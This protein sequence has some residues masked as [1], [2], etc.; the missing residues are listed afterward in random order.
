[1]KIFRSSF[2]KIVRFIA[3]VTLFLFSW[4][5]LTQ[6]LPSSVYSIKIPE[7]YGRVKQRWRAEE[8][9]TTKHKSAE[10]TK[11]IIH[12]QDAHTSSEAQ[13]NI[14]RIIEHLVREESLNIIGV[15]GAVGEIDLSRFRSFP[16]KDARDIVAEEF[17]EKGIFGG[18]EYSAIHSQ[19]EFTL[20]GA[21]D[22]A[23]FRDNFK[24]Y[25]ETLNAKEDILSDIAQLET[26]LALLREK[27]F[28]LELKSFYNSL[29]AYMDGNI[30]FVQ[31]APF[32]F[33]ALEKSYE[34]SSLSRENFLIDYPELSRFK[35]ILYMESVLDIEKARSERT[36]IVAEL[37][38]ELNPSDLA[39]AKLETYHALFLQTKITEKEFQQL[40]TALCQQYGVSRT[41]FRAFH[42]YQTYLEKYAQLD[43]TRLMNEVVRLAQVTFF[44]LAKNRDEKLLAETSYHVTLLKKLCELRAVNE[45]VDY[46]RSHTNFFHAETLVQ[47]IGELSARYNIQF[48]S[49]RP[50]ETLK[51]ALQNVEKFYSGAENRNTALIANLLNQLDERGESTGV[52]VGGGYHTEGLTEELRGQGINYLVVTPAIASLSE[53]VPYIEKMTGKLYPLQPQLISNITGLSTYISENIETLLTDFNHESA[54]ESIRKELLSIKLNDMGK[55]ITSLKALHDS[56]TG[57]N[58]DALIDAVLTVVQE[59]LEAGEFDERL[60]ISNVSRKEIRT[61]LDT[62]KIRDDL[63][64]TLNAFLIGDSENEKHALGDRRQR[65]D[66]RD[67]ERDSRNDRRKGDRR[68][69]DEHEKYGRILREN[70]SYKK[71]VRMADSRVGEPIATDDIRVLTAMLRSQNPLSTIVPSKPLS[72]MTPEEKEI[73]IEK[74]DKIVTFRI[75]GAARKNGWLGIKTSNDILGF[76]AT[77]QIIQLMRSLFALAVREEGLIERKRSIIESTYKSITFLVKNKN[78]ND[79]RERVEMVLSRVQNAMHAIFKGGSESDIEEALRVLG[80][81][82]D[83]FIQEAQSL[84]RVLQGLNLDLDDIQYQVDIG[85]SVVQDSTNDA[86]INAIIN[87]NQAI[88]LSHFNDSPLFSREAYKDFIREYR[89]LRLTLG[90]NAPDLFSDSEKTIL[91]GDVLDALRAQKSWDALKAENPNVAVLFKSE[92]HYGTCQKLFSY[93][94]VQD[95]IKRWEVDFEGAFTRA[96][97]A[98][99]LIESIENLTERARD[100]VITV[101]S[102]DLRLFNEARALIDGETKNPNL[103]SHL[104]FHGR[105]PP[106][107]DP[108]YVTI[109]VKKMGIKNLTTFQTE[110]AQ[111][112][113]ALFGERE[114][115]QT[116]EK[117]WRTAADRVTIDFIANV[118]KIIAEFKRRGVTISP[119]K[120]AIMLGGDECTFVLDGARDIVTPELLTWILTETGTRV[121]ASKAIGVYR[122]N[123]QGRE[124]QNELAHAE[125]LLKLEGD[126][127]GS[128]EGGGINRLKRYE[129]KGIDTV[130]IMQNEDASWTEYP[131]KIK[132]VSLYD[133]LR[134][135]RDQDRTIPFV[136]MDTVTPLHFAEMFRLI[137]EERGSHAMLLQKKFVWDTLCSTLGYR[138]LVSESNPFFNLLFAEI[139]ETAVRRESTNAYKNLKKLIQRENAEIYELGRMNLS[140]EDE[141]LFE[142]EW[143]RSLEHKAFMRVSTIRALLVEIKET[144]GALFPDETYEA[145]FNALESDLNAFIETNM[146]V[147]LRYPW[148]WYYTVEELIAILEKRD[149]QEIDINS[150]RRDATI[151]LLSKITGPTEIMTAYGTRIVSPHDLARL[152]AHYKN[153]LFAGELYLEKEAV[154]SDIMNA[155]YM[156]WMELDYF[157]ALIERFDQ[158]VEQ[159]KLYKKRYYSEAWERLTRFIRDTKRT[160]LA[161]GV[162]QYK[163]G[164]SGFLSV[165]LEGRIRKDTQDSHAYFGPLSSL[166]MYAPFYVVVDHEKMIREGLIQSANDIRV[167]GE[168]KRDY[169][170][171]YIVPSENERDLLLFGLRE[172]LQNG[173]RVREERFNEETYTT[174]ED[175]LLTYDEYRAKESTSGIL[176]NQRGAVSVGVLPAM[177]GGIVLVSGVLTW[178]IPLITAGIFSLAVGGI[179][180]VIA[181]ALLKSKNVPHS[182]QIFS[183]YFTFKNQMPEV[184]SNAEHQ[185][186][187]E[188]LDSLRLIYK[189]LNPTKLAEEAFIAI[190]RLSDI[191]EKVKEESIPD[192][193]EIIMLDKNKGES[194]FLRGVEPAY[195][196]LPI[197]LLVTDPF[198]SEDA[199][200]TLLIEKYEKEIERFYSEA[201]KRGEEQWL[202]VMDSLGRLQKMIDAGVLSWRDVKEVM[203]YSGD[204]IEAAVKNIEAFQ[205]ILKKGDL[206]Y[207]FKVAQLIQEANNALHLQFNAR[208]GSNFFSVLAQPLNVM[209]IEEL[210]I[211]ALYFMMSEAIKF[212]TFRYQ[213]LFKPEVVLEFLTRCIIEN[214][215][216][217]RDVIKLLSVYEKAPSGKLDFNITDYAHIH[218]EIFKKLQMYADHRNPLKERIF[219]YYGVRFVASQVSRLI[220]GRDLFDELDRLMRVGSFFEKETFLELIDGMTLRNLSDVL[221]TFHYLYVDFDDPLK[222]KRELPLFLKL[223][224]DFEEYFGSDTILN[225]YPHIAQFKPLV[226]T[227]D[228][229]RTL[230]D[231]LI[232]MKERAKDKAPFLFNVGLPFLQDA[233]TSFDEIE[234]ATNDFLKTFQHCTGVEGRTESAIQRFYLFKKKF[235]DIWDLFIKPVIFDQTVGAHLVLESALPLFNYTDALESNAD[236]IA[237]RE[238]IKAEGVQAF[239]TLENFVCRAYSEGFM[240][241]AFSKEVENIRD[242]LKEIPY[243]LIEVYAAYKENEGEAASLKERCEIIHARIVA[244]EVSDLEN[245]PLFSAILYYAFPPT[246]TTDR[247]RYEAIM[248]SREDRL[249][250]TLMIPESLQN[251]SVSLQRGTYT[252]KDPS[253]P[254]DESPWQTLLTGV[255]HVN[256]A[257]LR[258]YTESDR[259]ALAEMILTH[260]QKGDLYPARETLYT[261]IYAYY[262]A[263]REV[264]LPD[265]VNTVQNVMALKQFMGDTMIDVI[266]EILEAYQKEKSDEFSRVIEK[267]LKNTI[268]KPEGK[269]K[270]IVGIRKRFSGDIHEIKTRVQGVLRIDDESA[271]N[272]VWNLIEHL[273]T[274]SEITGALQDVRLVINDEKP[275]LIISHLLQ[276]S[277][278]RAMQSEVSTKFTFHESEGLKNVRFVVS[279]RKAHGVAGLN[280]G[281]CVAPDKELW[282]NPNFMNVIIFDDENIALGGMHL[283]ILEENGK[284]YVTL[285][286]INPSPRLLTQVSSEELYEEMI[287]YAHEINGAL[288]CDG[289]LIPTESGIHSNRSDMQR[290]ISSRTYKTFRFDEIKDFSFS[291]FKY[292]IQDCFIVPDPDAR[293]L[294]S[295]VASPAG[296]YNQRGSIAPFFGVFLCGLTA[297]G[298]FIAPSISSFTSI[299]S[300]H[301]KILL[302]TSVLCVSGAVF[303]IYSIDTLYEFLTREKDESKERVTILRKAGDFLGAQKARLILRP[304]FRIVNFIEK[305]RGHYLWVTIDK[306]TVTFEKGAYR[307]SGESRNF[308]RSDELIA[309]LAPSDS[310]NLM[311]VVHAARDGSIMRDLVNQGYTRIYAVAFSPDI[312]RLLS[313]IG[314][315]ELVYPRKEMDQYMIETG[316]EYSI[317]AEAFPALYRG[318]MNENPKLYVYELSL[319]DKESGS[320]QAELQE[321]VPRAIRPDQIEALMRI[322]NPRAALLPLAWNGL[323]REDE[324]PPLY[325][326]DIVRFSDYLGSRTDKAE[327]L[328]TLTLY[329]ILWSA[330]YTHEKRS[331]LQDALYALIFES[332]T[333]SEREALERRVAELLLA[334]DTASV[335]IQNMFNVLN[336]L[337]EAFRAEG[338]IESF[339]EIYTEI[340]ARL[341]PLAR[342][343]NSS[344]PEIHLIG[345]TEQNAPDTAR[346][347]AKDILKISGLSS[348]NGIDYVQSAK[349]LDTKVI[350]FVQEEEYTRF[351]ESLRAILKAFDTVIDLRVISEAR[352]TATVSELTDTDKKRAVVVSGKEPEEELLRDVRWLIFNEFDAAHF[353][354]FMAIMNALINL[355]HDQTVL[356]VFDIDS[357]N[358]NIVRVNTLYLTTI[359][360]QVSPAFLSEV[361][362]AIEGVIVRRQIDIAA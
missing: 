30:N 211:D 39:R 42:S 20:F 66:R 289:V 299:L 293:P 31:F 324:Y 37:M 123:F 208:G 294:F 99:E 353:I 221:A 174:I 107:R 204:S 292:Q 196:K 351:D 300:A 28:S 41:R 282:N 184:S 347:R 307:E 12:I 249:L 135:E 90:K 94:N 313:F 194:P 147:S 244:G 200:F 78:R 358:P 185:T 84:W 87:A 286:G 69:T 197:E 335:N 4:T 189:E 198:L 141:I 258:T 337:F 356:P 311:R 323:Q 183:E 227:M 346:E 142:E 306:G 218:E 247:T 60:H 67:S 22:E 121:A 75:P 165:I 17:V 171:Y 348:L 2:S 45:D 319:S 288:G 339:N 109:D 35:E 110:L 15:E 261:E 316:M 345:L 209:V 7:E 305:L 318:E 128:K 238:F 322:T 167:P 97:R 355:I 277:E 162:A 259:I 72:E 342:T 40:L 47:T 230:L 248:S 77:T 131:T 192:V 195:L 287:R 70:E 343:L 172:A 246:V 245:D 38:R 243:P 82:D 65:T 50:H 62:Q 74:D 330:F 341:A 93:I 32:L 168:L 54:A 222:A 86:R 125:M 164:I 344:F 272:G 116:V 283:L 146:P 191:G 326:R 19:K 169:H 153:H 96:Q 63:R 254:L 16:L 98:G 140:E 103:S 281:V 362:K 203:R 88:V 102:D 23:L 338:K 213:N 239:D 53:D 182:M 101:T 133:E 106:M 112:E 267:M 124:I 68:D 157:S 340:F 207:F 160:V 271:F 278:Y 219:E 114:D 33:E 91:R 59:K 265:D 173:L 236:V 216:P 190:L 234:K 325:A 152:P 21:E 237:L 6:A 210:G 137:T 126:T 118:E 240:R 296:L 170:K 27:V 291:P 290:V 304:F 159:Q 10:D 357:D 297:L 48:E 177:L 262:R 117:V 187:R 134:K 127:D 274:E 64:I 352:L 264:T 217:D 317:M 354:G 225:L 309:H 270:A 148:N 120:F 57:I 179:S 241:E 315:N 58:T 161:H 166:Y 232:T 18:A 150:Y 3:S 113:A 9:T 71:V 119:E 85:A 302:S 280:M 260:W 268:D 100:G 284:K 212:E 139:D 95:Y 122:H 333:V 24:T 83:T 25:Y 34:E 321:N 43:F 350:L 285:P 175:K 81:T 178:N 80:I 242:F 76:E 46:F 235:P 154:T 163:G 255:R 143:E 44:S 188:K 79:F 223:L 279:K 266:R 56:G 205:P 256:R 233:Y 26:V 349:A 224:R 359:I 180:S 136:W 156:P 176:T 8:A 257:D 181:S 334:D 276:G 312:E 252:L 215:I 155:S 251:R 151:A 158:Y 111:I 250:D 138:D 89:A 298:F 11:T 201:R 132:S 253:V 52:L 269:A 55:I 92:E 320:L 49:S 360:N 308:A 331:V 220:G 115:W 29:S 36:E 149:I 108:V 301:A 193:L 263:T 361:E 129:K 328:K 130:V 229:M 273:E 13:K 310:V 329:Q 5:T 275:A 1:M 295:E 314:F 336:T 145:L 231:F 51:S 228:D 214:A 61:F 186:L 303:L 105:A 199:H 73:T 202:A 206:E 14:A 327:L 332:H 104:S 144:Y 226:K